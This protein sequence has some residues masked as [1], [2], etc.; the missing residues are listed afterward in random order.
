MQKFPRDFQFPVTV[1]YLLG[2]ELPAELKV[3]HSWRS[4]SS[5]TLKSRRSSR[6]VNAG[7]FPPAHEWQSR[8]GC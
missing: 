7:F 6:S 3:S 8:A 4:P 5:R 1:P 2:G